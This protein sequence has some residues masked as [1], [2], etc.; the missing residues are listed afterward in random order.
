MGIRLLTL[1]QDKVKCSI[2]LLH[3]FNCRTSQTLRKQYLLIKE[4]EKNVFQGNLLRSSE[5]IIRNW[6]IQ[7]NH[8]KFV[9][10]FGW[11]NKYII[12]Y[13]IINNL[14]QVSW[15]TTKQFKFFSLRSNGKFF[16]PYINFWPT[17]NTVNSTISA[18]SSIGWMVSIE[19]IAITCIGL[20]LQQWMLLEVFW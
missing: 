4:T 12:Y 11:H 18:C 6:I 8:Q 3:P 19:A 9:F 16:K 14:A 10:Y 20:G 13:S 2:G 7:S 15:H 17:S 5:P 1:T